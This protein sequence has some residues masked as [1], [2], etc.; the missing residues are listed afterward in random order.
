[1]EAPQTITTA[2]KRKGRGKI[3]AAIAVT[4]LVTAVLTAF[5]IYLRYK[6]VFALEAAME[7]V[8]QNYYFYD[9]E[10]N[11]MTADALRGIADGLGDDY[12]QY[13]TDLEF[14]QLNA[15]NS[16]R[17]I[18]VGIVVEYVED[19][20]FIIRTV[21]NDSPAFEAGVMSGDQLIKINGVGCTGLDLQ[22]FLDNFLHEEGDSND[23]V[24]LREGQELGFT[25]V[26]REVY[27]PYVSYE[28]L[29]NN[30]GYIHISG[31]HGQCVDEMSAALEELQLGG[32]T[33]LVLDLR[34][35][36]GGSLYD[37][38]DV[39]EMFLPKNSLI[40]TVK[41][42]KGVSHEYR[43]GSTDGLKMPIA[44]LVNSYSASAS[45]LLSGALKDHGVAT[46]FGQTTYGKGIVQTYFPLGIGMGYMKFT[47]EAYYTPNGVCIQGTGIVPDF[48][49]AL[50]D[51]FLD[52]DI[53][54]IP[55][56]EDAQL[57][58]AIDWLSEQ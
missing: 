25:L 39:A 47:T 2:P 46:L 34:D 1:M 4:F 24:V 41:S 53:A 32:M 18:G 49:I 9:E 50:D 35:N 42:R 36:L 29:A 38:V 17:Y 3:I 27:S 16:G 28:L 5:V 13:Y 43:T 54:S 11:D 52:Y 56:N 14:E 58:A 15:T 30:I 10:Q 51:R 48:E 7:I 22:S 6:N 33:R 44:L 23:I 57:L 55:H 21:Y 20:T 8:E 45:E 40:T 19:S 37:V 12:S 26:M 31:F